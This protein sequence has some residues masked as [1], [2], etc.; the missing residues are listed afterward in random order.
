MGTDQPTDQPTDKP[1]DRPTK[2]GIESRSTRLKILMERV[3]TLLIKTKIT[4]GSASVV[5]QKNLWAVAVKLL[6]DN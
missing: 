3:K 6:L 1:T 4:C 5:M 2:R